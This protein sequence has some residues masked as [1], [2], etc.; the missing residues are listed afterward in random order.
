MGGIFS[1]KCNVM[2]TKETIWMSVAFEYG[3]QRISAKMG[4]KMDAVHLFPTFHPLLQWNSNQ[5]IQSVIFSLQTKRSI[6]YCLHMQCISFALISIGWLTYWCFNLHNQLCKLHK[7][8]NFA[9]ACSRKNNILA[10]D[11]LQRDEHRSAFDKCWVEWKN[12]VFLHP[13]PWEVPMDFLRPDIP[14]SN[15][16]GLREGGGLKL[17][18]LP[19]PCLPTK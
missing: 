3:C 8:C 2:E 7:L 11:D 15:M 5:W 1:P 19:T 14:W 4:M 17:S 6:L 9:I 13:S 16:V 18:P 12:C 10:E